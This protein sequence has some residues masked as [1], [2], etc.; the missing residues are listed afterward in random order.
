M[1]VEKFSFSEGEGLIVCAGDGKFYIY[2]LNRQSDNKAV[3]ELV[4]RRP[5]DGDH[6]QRR[7]SCPV[8]EIQAL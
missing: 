4:R 5:P 3:R 1:A 6:E 7:A 8:K 2:R